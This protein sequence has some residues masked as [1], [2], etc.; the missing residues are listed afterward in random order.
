M[1]PRLVEDLA[2]GR[3]AGDI[4]PPADEVAAV[5][6][7]G[8]GAELRELFARAA[9]AVTG[10]R[11]I[12]VIEGIH[13]IGKTALLTHTLAQLAG[14]SKLRAD[15]AGGVAADQLIRQA[16]QA[17][18]V[19][20]NARS[21]GSLLTATRAM[22]AASGP[23]AIALDNLDRIDAYSADE[24]SQT[25]PALLSSP[26]LVIV[27]IRDP[28]PPS[29]R[30]AP[31][32][33]RLRRQLDGGQLAGANLSRLRLGELSLAETGQLI[34][35]MAGGARP[36]Q[37]VAEQLHRYTGGHPGLLSALL[38]QGQ[39]LTRTDPADRLGLFEPFVV[40]ILREVSA[41]PAPSL[42]LLTALAVTQEPWPLATVGSVAQVEEPFEAL[43]P[44]LDAG[45]AEWFPAQTVAPVAI[46][47]PLYRDVIYRS[48]PAA[49][50]DALHARASSFAIGTQSW[51][52]QVAASRTSEPTLAL[53]LEQEAERYYLAGDNE[54]AGTLLRWSV[55]ATTDRSERDRRLLL[56][57]RW[58]LTLRA[59]DWGPQLES[60]LTRWPPSA[61]RS[62][63][64]GLLAEAA[65]RYG[66]ARGLLAQAQELARTDDSALV[67]R[68][69]LELAM[70]LVCADLGD[71]DTQYRLAAEV[72]TLD[73]LS[74]VQR[75]WAEYHVA[76]AWGR[77][78]GPQAALAKL[79]V[80]AAS[81]PTVDSGSGQGGPVISPSVRLWTRA[82]LQVLSGR[83]HDA[84][85]DLI[86]LLRAADRSA[87]DS[88]L[89]MA[90]AYLGYTHYLLGDWKAAEHAADQAVT[91]LSGQAV[92]RLRVPAHAVAACVDAAAGRSD[93]AARHVQ[94]AW[95]WYA[96]C[97]PEDFAVFPALAAATAAQ[98]RGDYGRML[99]A[100]QPLLAG[101]AQGRREW[102]DVWWRPL[103]VEALIGTG[104]L[105]AARYALDRLAGL[106]DDPEN[107]SVTVVW[108]DA[109][110]AAASNDQPGAKARFDEAS[111]RPAAPDDV[112]LHQ[113][114]L[115]HEHGRYLMSGRTRRTA[116]GA[117]R[118]AYELYRDLGARPFA[119]RCARD[120]ELCGALAGV[121][122]HGGALAVLSSRERR[123]AYLAA[124]GLT[125][126][127]IS[128]EVF[129]S[130]KTV[131]YHLSNVFAKLGISSR[132]QLPARLGRDE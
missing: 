98:A 45:L 18:Q 55:D 128:A 105:A 110:L 21:P 46:R 30:D 100:L 39:A 44:L 114:R 79:A 122:A 52:H 117:L 49:R 11:Q 74:A 15:C 42:D 82:T 53:T 72:L 69:D 12:V 124:Q 35:R 99:A 17:A 25:L 77:V 86:R 62:L 31:P 32:V 81:E 23:L 130:T 1:R 89:P 107:P 33:E 40:D 111:V 56:A 109:W 66:Q 103:Y 14:F 73:G 41:L 24:L 80:L 64:L 59:V 61:P 102:H 6:F 108:L 121:P 131:E 16:F 13:G 3:A 125:N 83:L 115:E 93:A 87:V 19:V 34:D 8:R 118:R 9:A 90:H 2:A 70:A 63:I 47:Y 97:A 94:T 116:I 123:I 106:A 112:P 85:S 76:D 26:L 36:A 68:P 119:E 43:E 127:E 91:A 7:L 67:L 48:T 22:M 37:Q 27:A 78:H 57:A 65:G 96:E 60:C 88:V 29:H 38:R 4:G 101:T 71:V 126:Q 20:P 84:R 5:P 28:W 58:S 75:G 129:V 92:A 54:Q 50:R 113:A 120:L 132:R 51:A 10:Q 104:Q 95:H